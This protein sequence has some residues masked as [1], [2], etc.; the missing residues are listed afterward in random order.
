[1]LTFQAL[2]TDPFFFLKLGYQRYKY[3]WKN[4]TIF[5]NQAFTKQ[6]MGQIIPQNIRNQ[7]NIIYEWQ[8]IVGG[9]IYSYVGEI[10]MLLEEHCGRELDH[11]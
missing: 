3:N 9:I 1:M 8:F 4:G 6:L 5:Q 10:T 11:T 2:V 7:R